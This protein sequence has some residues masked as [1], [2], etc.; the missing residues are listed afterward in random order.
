MI[1]TVPLPPNAANARRHWR[2]ALKEKKAYWERLALMK[3]PP[4]D[5]YL[6]PLVAHISVTMYVHNI[7]DPD[8]A[9]ARLKPLLDWLVAWDYIAD[10]SP[11][12]LKWAGLPEQVIDRKNPRVVLEIKSIAE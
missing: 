7:M 12:A 11:K 2:V 4:P 10:D 5:C 3:R 9:M 8:N 1:L 6:P